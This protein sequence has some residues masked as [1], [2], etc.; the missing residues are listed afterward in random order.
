MMRTLI[1]NAVILDGLGPLLR[2]GRVLVCDAK[3]E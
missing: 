3:T 1:D 2:P